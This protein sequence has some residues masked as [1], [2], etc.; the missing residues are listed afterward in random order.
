MPTNNLQEKH[1]FL[2]KIRA[3]LTI[4]KQW[5]SF[6]LLCMF[7]SICVCGYQLDVVLRYRTA[8]RHKTLAGI[9][10]RAQTFNFHS[11]LSQVNSE[12]C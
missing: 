5:N 9:S 1:L 12:F 3:V 7:L 2:L 8:Q 4:S 11:S 10:V 6:N